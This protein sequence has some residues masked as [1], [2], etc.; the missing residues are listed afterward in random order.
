MVP[1]LLGITLI[2]FVVIR[3]APGEP[4][5]AMTAL[6]PKVSA[7]TRQRIRQFYGLDRPL[8]EQYVSWLGRIVQLDFGRSFAPLNSCGIFNRPSSA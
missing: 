4:V 1:L 6:S 5:E 3:L 7:E 8:H 2:T